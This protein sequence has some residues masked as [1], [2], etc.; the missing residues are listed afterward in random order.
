MWFVLCGKSTNKST[1]THS[2]AHN[3]CIQHACENRERAWDNRNEWTNNPTILKQKQKQNQ[4]FQNVR[5]FYSHSVDAFEA[6]C[7]MLQHLHAYSSS[8]TFSWLRGW[9]RSEKREKRRERLIEMSCEQKIVTINIWNEN[10]FFSLV[11]KLL[12]DWHLLFE[13]QYFE[14]LGILCCAMPL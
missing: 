3:A 14:L 8:N 10:T 7:P 11:S 13:N 1:H 9:K 12:D 5:V 6:V 4:I 2:F